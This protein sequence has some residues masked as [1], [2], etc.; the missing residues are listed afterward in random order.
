M[1]LGHEPGQTL[2]PLREQVWR[3]AARARDDTYFAGAT[4]A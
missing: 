4:A 2:A 3:R 1:H